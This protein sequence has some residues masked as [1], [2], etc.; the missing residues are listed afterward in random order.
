MLS[1][2]PGLE[3]VTELQPPGTTLPQ[4]LCGLRGAG[5]AASQRASASHEAFGSQ[6]GDDDGDD[7]HGDCRDTHI[8]T[9]TSLAFFVA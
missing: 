2:E 6:C 9:Q 5:E 1:W 4:G 7:G 8:D 3:K